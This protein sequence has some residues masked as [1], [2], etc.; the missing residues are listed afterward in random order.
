[1]A[2]QHIGVRQDLKTEL[3]QSLRTLATSKQYGLEETKASCYTTIQRALRDG[4]FLFEREQLVNLISLLGNE[5]GENMEKAWEAIKRYLPEP[6]SSQPLDVLA[7]AANVPLLILSEIRFFEAMH[8]VSSLADETIANVNSKEKFLKSIRG[9][10][11]C[12]RYCAKEGQDDG[13]SLPSPLFLRRGVS[14]GGGL[15]KLAH[16]FSQ[17]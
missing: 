9:D 17:K 6:L 10:E 4:P 13:A 3:A 5:E 1:M 7:G 16:L 11:L 12:G 2:R 15:T 14:R 8:R